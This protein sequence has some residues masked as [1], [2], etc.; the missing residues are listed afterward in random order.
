MLV[1]QLLQYFCV[2]FLDH[3]VW[4]YSYIFTKTLYFWF[5]L[6]HVILLYYLSKP[7][8]SLSCPLIALFPGHKMWDTFA[9][10][11]FDLKAEP[12][13]DLKLRTKH[14]GDNSRSLW[15]NS[16]QAKCFSR[17][18][19]GRKIMQTQKILA[20]LLSSPRSYRVFRNLLHTL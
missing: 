16:F 17:I 3:L 15:R 9:F 18:Q 7:L 8:T 2:V 12:G 10:D 5:F 11:C 6:T 13:M 20:Q 19:R 1:S 4:K 14:G